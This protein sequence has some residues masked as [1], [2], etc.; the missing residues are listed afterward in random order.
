MSP[1]EALQL[2][3][4]QASQNGREY[5]YVRSLFD[6]IRQL[7]VK[8]SP[9]IS[10]RDLNITALEQVDVLRKANQAL[11]MS[12]IFT[13]EVGLRDMDQNFLEVFVPEQGR[14][15]KAQGSIYLELKTQAF[16]TANRTAAAQPLLVMAELFPHDIESK[17]LET[18]PGQKTLAPSE[19][20][21]LKR[22]S[23]RRDILLADIRNRTLDQLPMRYRWED[24]SREVSAYLI[25]NF[26]SSPTNA[27]ALSNTSQASSIVA[28]QPQS[29]LQG[30]FSIHEPPMP[31]SSAIPPPFPST[32]YSVSA[33]LPALD[34]EDFV[35][36]A[37]RAAEIAM[38]G[39]AVPF[40]IPEQVE[41]PV[42]QPTTQQKTDTKFQLY[43]PNVTASNGGKAAIFPAGHDEIPHSSQTA[44]THVL[45][46]RARQVATA[47]STPTSR[48]LMTPSQRRPWTPEEEAALMTGL[49]QVKGPHWSQILAMYGPGG[50]VNESLKDR[51][52][53]QL[54]DKARN[55]KL[56][57][58]KADI[59]VPYYLKYVTGDLRTRA[60]G[61]A[62]KQEARERERL[63]SDGIHDNVGTEGSHGSSEEYESP[64]MSPPDGDELEQG[65]EDPP[66]D[67]ASAALPDPD[68]MDVEA[69]IARA[70]AQ[71]SESF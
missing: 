31:P 71:A 52:Q 47:K 62:E 9:F 41:A 36:Q 48:K 43:D 25:R 35:L 68:M 56:F 38:Q 13:G 54:K 3:R 33:G 44:P 51:N 24:L 19:Q 27:A 22:M 37:A 17:L 63:Q 59:E 39:P 46:E 55:L 10:P 32:N 66:V 20:D 64:P 57:F 60:P 26:S 40:E 30:E 69:M 7:Y 53:V 18:R 45:Y 29:H 1:A 49:D 8:N 23:S 14:L 21:F 4:T 58:L 2:S 11:Y 67:E 28:S 15:L 50:T 61:Q 34:L 12:S 65:P 6:P 16:I 5:Q 42:I 70:A